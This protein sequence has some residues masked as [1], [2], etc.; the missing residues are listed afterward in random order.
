MRMP[1]SSLNHNL[2]AVPWVPT[3]D[4]QRTIGPA[5]EPS[6]P[7]RWRRSEMRQTPLPDPARQAGRYSRRQLDVDYHELN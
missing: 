3:A 7:K 5:R 1:K 2:I 4:I 6:L